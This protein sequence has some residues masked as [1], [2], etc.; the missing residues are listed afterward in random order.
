MRPL[1]FLFVIALIFYTIAILSHKKMGVLK[2]WMIVVFGIGL[3]ADLSGT[4]FLC[5][6]HSAG[7]VWNLHTISGLAALVIMFLHF[8]WALLSLLKKD[9]FEEK[10]NRYSVYAW[11]LW[12]ISFMSGIPM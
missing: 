3:L 1:E 9:Q 10:F 6:L 12:L 5:V 11:C 8:V 7:W 4:I 2:L